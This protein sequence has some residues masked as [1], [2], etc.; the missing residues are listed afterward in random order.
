MREFTTI[1][2]TG[3]GLS[4][5][6]VGSGFIAIGYLQLNNAQDSLKWP[7]TG[8]VIISSEIKKSEY[9]N[10]T[11]YHANVLYK[12]AVG[13]KLYS[14]ERVS[15]GQ[16]GSNDPEHARSIVRRYEKGQNISVYFNP[17]DPNKSVLEPGVSWGAYIFLGMSIGFFGLGAFTAVLFGFIAPK[18]EQKRTESL[19]QAASTLGL[20]FLEEGIA[21][22]SED[23]WEFPLFRLG[24]SREISNILYKESATGRIFLFDYQFQ[25]VYGENS[26]QYVQTVAAFFFFY[27]NLP[28]FSLK[29]KEINI[30]IFDRVREFFLR[31][32]FG[33]QDIKIESSPEFSKCYRLQ[34]QLEPAIRKVFNFNVLQFFSQNP[35]WWLEGGSKWLVIY[36]L[37]SQVKPEEI[38]TFLQQTSQIS[39]LFSY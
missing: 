11:T 22:E 35:V 14:S 12:Y 1:M 10:S 17:A 2:G 25:D 38:G 18:L 20:N 9:E 15:F 16:Y 39:Q 34:G 21:L 23:F 19:R 7:T 36:R 24:S 26:R 13:E 6:V 29:P 31:D 5:M 28:E 37:K 33:R 27:L 8:G 32:L 4:F 30:N 3:I